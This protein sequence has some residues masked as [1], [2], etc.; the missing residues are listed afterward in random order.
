MPGKTDLSQLNCS[1]A[2]TL[3][4]VGDWWTLLIVRDAF[5]GASRFGEFH[6]SLGIARNI[7]ATRLERLVANGIFD[8]QGPAR[9]PR[10]RLTHKG[11]ELA[12]GLVGLMQWGDRWVSG[13]LPPILVTDDRGVPLAPLEL[14]T[15]QG[16]VS[17]ASLR[18]APGPGATP[19]TRAFLS[20]SK[21][22]KDG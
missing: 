8:R 19:R 1:L 3:E 15:S 14:R 12:P 22:A 11:S 2:R 21:A 17:P 16:A 18:F 4:E 7:L 20:K 6:H 10:Y 9:R 13:N 5:L